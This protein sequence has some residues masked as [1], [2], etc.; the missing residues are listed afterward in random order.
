MSLRN[1]RI[2]YRWIRRNL[3][4]SL[5][6]NRSNKSRSMLAF[7]VNVKKSYLMDSVGWM[8]GWLAGRSVGWSGCMCLYAV[9]FRFSFIGFVWKCQVTFSTVLRRNF[10]ATIELLCFHFSRRK[11]ERTLLFSLFWM[12]FNLN[13]SKLYYFKSGK[14]KKREEFMTQHKAHSTQHSNLSSETESTEEYI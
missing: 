2:A 5:N 3:C 9:F 4:W 13:W 1:K 8:V 14:I 6:N 7:A 11:Y 12:P 10:N